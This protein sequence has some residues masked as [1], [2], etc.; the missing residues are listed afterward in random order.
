MTSTDVGTPVWLSTRQAKRRIGEIW[1]GSAPL[2]Q[3]LNA[4][5]GTLHL[6]PEE[7]R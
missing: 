3:W 6:A 5:V 1:R 7:P 4:N 2:V